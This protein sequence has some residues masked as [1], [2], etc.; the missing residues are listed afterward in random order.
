MSA[1]L[2]QSFVIGTID[3]RSSRSKRNDDDIEEQKVKVKKEDL[4]NG[5]IWHI[6]DIYRFLAAP[7]LQ[8]MNSSKLDIQ[9]E[10]A[11][12]N[13]NLITVMKDELDLIEHSETLANNSGLNTIIELWKTYTAMRKNLYGILYL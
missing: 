13:S 1:D 7:W 11:L 6:G 3:K 12:V 10:I 4:I 8:T 9:E 5:R 2:N